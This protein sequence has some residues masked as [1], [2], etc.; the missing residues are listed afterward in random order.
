MFE[1][2][3]EIFI[4]INF[5]IL[6]NVVAHTNNR[7]LRAISLLTA[8]QITTNVTYKISYTIED[9]ELQEIVTSSIKAVLITFSGS[10]LFRLYYE[11][12]NSQNK[13]A[14]GL[15]Q[16]H[17]LNGFYAMGRLD[18]LTCDFSKY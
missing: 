14:F 8:A 16:Q 18:C 13:E 10:M 3:Y 1:S 6:V 12:T 17:I 11:S 2:F 7:L 4:H 5:K 9:G 15:Q